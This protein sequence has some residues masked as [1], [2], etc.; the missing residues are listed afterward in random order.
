M[1]RFTFKNGDDVWC[2][3]DDSCFEE[4]SEHYCGPAIERLAYYEDLEERGRLCEKRGYWREVDSSYWRWSCSGGLVPYAKSASDGLFVVKDFV[5]HDGHQGVHTLITA[6]GKD[7][8][9]SLLSQM[10]C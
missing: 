7:L 1:K 6:K 10:C 8:F 2:V 5:A 4:Q 9:Y 3:C